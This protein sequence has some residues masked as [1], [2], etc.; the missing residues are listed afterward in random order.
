MVNKPEPIE[1][2]G[3]VFARRYWKSSVSAEAESK[4]HAYSL[5]TRQYRLVE[6][7]SATY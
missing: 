2:A 3:T 1:N 5:V 7:Y 6:G 4:A